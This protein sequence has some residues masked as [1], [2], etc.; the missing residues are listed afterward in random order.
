[1]LT[2]RKNVVN[3]YVDRSTQ[4]WIVLDAD[5]NFWTVSTL[6]ENPWADWSAHPFVAGRAQ[7]LLLSNTASLY[8]TVIYGRGV[9]TDS[10]FIERALGG[11]R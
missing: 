6:D 2:L 8:S 5:G 7:Y 3:L 9:T 11:I 10:H 4:Q 1:M